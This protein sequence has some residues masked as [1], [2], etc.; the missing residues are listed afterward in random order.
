MFFVFTFFDDFFFC[1]SILIPFYQITKSWEN[2][3]W[4]DS[5]NNGGALRKSG[6]LAPTIQMNWNLKKFLPEDGSLQKFFQLIIAG[7]I[8]VST[9]AS[10][11]QTN[12]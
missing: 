8:Q 2:L 10:M 6:D 9:S 12:R 1:A 3:L 4:L 11:T 5:V 7:Y